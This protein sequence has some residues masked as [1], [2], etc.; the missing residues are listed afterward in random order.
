MN[1]GNREC[2]T[3]VSSRNR[4]E[5]TIDDLLAEYARIDAEQST[6]PD[7]WVASSELARR[8]V[9]STHEAR[10]MRVQKQIVAFSAAH[11]EKTRKVRINSKHVSCVELAA[12]MRW[13]KEER[14]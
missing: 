11:P 2:P 12:F 8:A 6:M 7:G 10:R 9:G 5:I 1:K 3:V 14:Q 13:L 4:A